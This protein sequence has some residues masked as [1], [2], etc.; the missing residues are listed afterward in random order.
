M[1]IH[2]SLKDCTNLREIPINTIIAEHKETVGEKEVQIKLLVCAETKYLCGENIYDEK[3]VSPGFLT[4]EFLK[5][6]NLISLDIKQLEFI[7]HVGNKEFGV[8]CDEDISE[9]TEEYLASQMALIAK[10]A[11]KVNHNT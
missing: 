6:K 9:W 3:D 2:R 10:W 4:A 1:I 11:A 8:I 5:R 7:C